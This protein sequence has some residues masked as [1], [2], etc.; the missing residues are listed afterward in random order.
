MAHAL[1]SAEEPPASNGC[2]VW[3][4]IRLEL[5]VEDLANTRFGISPLTETVFSLWA[6]SDPSRHTLHLPWLRTVRGR[7]SPTDAD[8][9]FS[10]VGPSRLPPDFRGNPSRALPDFLTPRP[11][12]FITRFHDELAAVR[13]TPPEIVR[14]DLVA[15]HAP[16][17]VPDG[18]QAATRSDDRPTLRLLGAICDALECHWKHSV[19]PSWPQM[20][21][22][23]EADTTYR[24]RQLATGGAR[25]LFADIHP[26][27]SWNDGVLRIDEMIGHHTGSRARDARGAA[28][29]GRA[30]APAQGHPKRRL[31]TPPGSPRHRPCHPRPRPPA[32][33]VSPHAHRRSAHHGRDRHRG[34]YGPSE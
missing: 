4:M 5:G 9:L 27:L 8:L 6:L 28:A 32:G 24:A 29:D 3:L 21:L 12:K 31:P 10:L 17:P 20:Q 15:T 7:L 26:N 33:P 34:K 18:L 2:S 19:A 30:R 13:A 25:L 11:A 14:R 16:D 22:V 1:S 23:L